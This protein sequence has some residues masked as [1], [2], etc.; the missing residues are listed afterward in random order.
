M[1]ASAG[2]QVPLDIIVFNPAS[3]F[4]ELYRLVDLSAVGDVRV[5]VPASP[6][7]SKA[8]Q[9]AASLRLPIRIM[10]GQPSAAALA[11]LREVLEFYLHG[12]T[13]EAPIEFFHSLLAAM[14]G[15]DTGSLWTIL[16]EHP[17]ALLHDDA[18]GGPSL[19]KFAR[20]ARWKFLPVY[21]WS[22][23]S[24]TWSRN[25]PNVRIAIGNRSAEGISNGPIRSM[26]VGGKALT[27][28]DR[29]GRRTDLAR[30]NKGTLTTAPRF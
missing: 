18:E 4:A 19:S 2:S 26:I 13:V 11:E 6:G 30:S 5:S 21:L 17:A 12:P 10:P 3:E 28:A 14:C 27:L 23:T 22:A 16:E 1:P 20:F 29:S 15:A 25:V 8:V 24:R 9:L 7:F